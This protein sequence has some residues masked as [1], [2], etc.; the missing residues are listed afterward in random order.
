MVN[1]RSDLVNRESD[2]VNRRSD[3]VNRESDLVNRESDL[4]RVCG[5]IDI[6]YS[7]N[8]D[9]KLRF[10]PQRNVRVTSLRVALCTL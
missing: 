4:V 3:L 5:T 10:S 7:R 6:I 2:L 1:R 8:R 9:G